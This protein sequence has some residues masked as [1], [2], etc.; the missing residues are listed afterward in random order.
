MIGI[1]EGKTANALGGKTARA[2]DSCLVKRARW[3][4]AADDAFLCQ[5]CDASV[6]SAN[7][8]ASRHERIR[9][10]TTSFKATK[11]NSSTP[12]WH[13]GFTKKART[14]RHSKSTRL[15]PPANHPLPLVPEINAEDLFVEEN[16]ELDLLHRVPVFE[17]FGHEFGSEIL[18]GVDGDDHDLNLEELLSTCDE[19]LAEFAA[20]VES[21]LGTTGTEEASGCGINEEIGIDEHLDGKKVKV[22]EDCDDEV[23]AVIA[24]HFDPALDMELNWNFDNASSMTGETGD[25]IK[26]EAA[27]ETTSNIDSGHES[28]VKKRLLLRLNYE[29]AIAAWATQGSPWTNGVRPRFDDLDEFMVACMGE[30][31]HPCGGVCGRSGAN[32][33]GREAKVSRYREKRRTRLFSKKIRYQVRKLNAEKRPRMKGRFVKR[34]TFSGSSLPYLMNK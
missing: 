23:Q 33:A 11:V 5:S 26:K 17:P 19:D 25:E 29:A 20:D 1:S 31:S 3:F 6:H 10:E 8:L 30:G 14:P 24:C 28:Q 21:L 2:C 16:E 34:T 22:E 12:A 27:V 9:L 7:Q 18:K 32:D 4:C 15:Q 13:Q